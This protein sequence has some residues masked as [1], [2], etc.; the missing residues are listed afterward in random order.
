MLRFRGV[1]AGIDATIFW[2]TRNVQ[3]VFATDL[4][5]T[6]GEGGLHGE[7]PMLAEP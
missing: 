5:V 2:L 3:R 7:T 6:S 1:G 4:Y